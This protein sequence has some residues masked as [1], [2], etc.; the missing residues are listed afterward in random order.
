MKNFLVGMSKT[1]LS[2]PYRVSYEQTQCR[3]PLIFFMLFVFGFQEANATAIEHIDIEL[4][5]S[6]EQ[7]LRL[8]KRLILFL[9]SLT[10][11]YI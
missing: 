11:Y 2:L 10:L 1:H 6:P 7:P 9:A 3:Y 5:N 4:S 8:G